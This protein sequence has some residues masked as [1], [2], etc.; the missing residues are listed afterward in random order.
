MSQENAASVRDPSC[1]SPVRRVRGGLLLALGV[2]ISLALPGAAPGAFPGANGRIA[3]VEPEPN[4][5]DIYTVLPDGSGTE[6]LT[7]NGVDDLFPSWSANGHRLTY[8]RGSYYGPNQVFTSGAQGGNKTQV[9]H[10]RGTLRSPHFSPSGGRIVYARLF[11]DKSWIFTIRSDGTDLRRVVTGD[12]LDSPS[13]SPNGRRIA[14]V[15]EPKGRRSGIWTI[16]ADGSHLRRLTRTGGDKNF[17]L[18]PE[19]APDGRHLMFVRCDVGA[20]DRT[21][22]G[23]LKLIRLDGSHRRTITSFFG[24]FSPPVFSPTGD[25]IALVHIEASLDDYFCSD[26]FTITLGGSDSG[27]ITDFCEQF[28]DRGTRRFAEQPSWQPIP[29]Q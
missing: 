13:Y 8:L 28:D 2:L 5:Y 14:F 29:A 3:Y 9:T 22:E 6:R 17:G 27:P 12:Y 26:I 4:T 21:C 23:D 18:F 19:W 16:E 1:T 11:F 7:D 10:E 25:R 20:S 24:H 15:G